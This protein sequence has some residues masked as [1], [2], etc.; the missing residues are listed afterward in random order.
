MKI[1]AAKPSSAQSQKREHLLGVALDLFYRH[2]FHN[3]GIDTILAQSGVAK[4]TLYKYFP[5]KEDLIVAV[6]ERRDA[7]F[8]SWLTR[9]AERCA[10]APLQRLLGVFEA[11][12][13]WFKGAR[14]H[15]CLFMNACAEYPDAAHPIHRAAALHKRQLYTFV[16]RLVEDLG[17]RD[18]V[19]LA[20]E[21]MLLLEGATVIAHVSTAPIAARRAKKAA[22]VL[23]KAALDT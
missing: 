11:Y 3:T 18:S 15:G 13:K 5:S 4:M 12:E 7:E 21:I 2:G 17:V 8:L 20:Q 10:G 14:F 19:L 16:L 23:I 9:E 1:A 22:E 6:L